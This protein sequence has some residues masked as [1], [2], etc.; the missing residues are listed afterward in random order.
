VVSENLAK[1]AYA[2]NTPIIVSNQAI[3]LKHEHE[4]VV[5][6]KFNPTLLQD[7]LM[8]CKY[9]KHISSFAVIFLMLSLLMFSTW[10]VVASL[11]CEK[12]QATNNMLLAV[13]VF[14]QLILMRQLHEIEFKDKEQVG[15]PITHL[16]IG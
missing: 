7:K 8:L 11:R 1:V 15:W 12:V 16:M 4:M 5:E 3:D 2:S 9:F 13:M 14:L 6:W 10:M